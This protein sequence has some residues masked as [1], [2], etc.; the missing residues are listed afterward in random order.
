MDLADIYRIFCST[1]KEYIFY[2][3]AYEN[4]SKINHTKQIFKNLK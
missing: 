4:F 1:I 3:A 2:T